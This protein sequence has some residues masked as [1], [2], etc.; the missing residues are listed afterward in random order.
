MTT[1]PGAAEQTHCA[2]CRKPLTD[3]LTGVLDRQEWDSRAAAEATRA[4]SRGQQLSLILVDLDRFKGVNDTYGHLAGDAVL[5]AAAAVLRGIEGGVTGRYGGHAG[6]EF[7][8]LLPGASAA[9]ALTTAQRAQE[10][11]RQLEVTARS[12]RSDTVRLTGQAASMGVATCRVA[13]GVR[14][15]LADLVLDA[16]V[17]LRTAKRAGGD[18]AVAATDAIGATE[19][20]GTTETEDAAARPGRRP[21]SHGAG[22]PALAPG[23]LSEV[24]R[25]GGVREDPPPHPEHQPAG[26]TGE[27]RIPLAAFEPDAHPAANDLVLS[28]PAAERLHSLLGELLGRPATGQAHPSAPASTS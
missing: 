9:Q 12:S 16:D 13:G 5:R 4:R 22:A 18:R 15:T 2:L 14:A 17:A 1:A 10:R 28:A 20:T 25:Q 7:L 23:V 19:A 24:P 27:L 6:D 8:I 11:I 21:P 26:Q 3:R